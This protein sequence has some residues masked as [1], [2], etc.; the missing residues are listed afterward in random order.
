MHQRNDGAV[1]IEDAER[2]G[3]T[4]KGIW[5]SAPDFDKDEFIPTQFIHDDSEVY[6]NGEFGDLIVKQYFAETI[7]GWI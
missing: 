6:R 3:Y 1:V 4:D 5:V 2:T 7:K